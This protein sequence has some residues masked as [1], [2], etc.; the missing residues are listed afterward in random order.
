MIITGG[1]RLLRDRGGMPMII[2]LS[3]GI[4]T[5]EIGLNARVRPR[6]E[7]GARVRIEKRKRK[8]AG[9]GGEREAGKGKQK[10]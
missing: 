3:V 1:Y 6:R 2:R 10:K 9:G 4:I 8:G 7:I 5:G